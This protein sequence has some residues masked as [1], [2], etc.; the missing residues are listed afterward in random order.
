RLEVVFLPSLELG[1]V[2]LALPRRVL[3]QHRRDRLVDVGFLVPR[4][5]VEPLLMAFHALAVASVSAF[6]FTKRMRYTNVDAGLALEGLALQIVRDEV[7][8]RLASAISRKD[9]RTRARV[10]RRKL[11]PRARQVQEGAA[12]LGI[13]VETERFPTQP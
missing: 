9:G 2:D 13:L 12:I 5:V 11:H 7:R 10:L 6:E 3:F 8:P 4:L 1:L